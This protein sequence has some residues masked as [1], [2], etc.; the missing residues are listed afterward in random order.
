MEQIYLREHWQLR[1]TSGEEWLETT[2]PGSVYPTYLEHGRM[3]DPFYRDNELKA[4]PLMEH[5]YEYRTRFDV[6]E[7]IWQEE[8]IELVFYGID[9]VADIFLNGELLLHTENMHRTWVLSVKK[10]WKIRQ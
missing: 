5:D 10:T 4:L 3:E 7:E 8:Q 1:D 9:T 2:V 6:P